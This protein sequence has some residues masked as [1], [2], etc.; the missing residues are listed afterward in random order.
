VPVRDLQEQQSRE[1]MIQVDGGLPVHRVHVPPGHLSGPTA[2]A[3]PVQDAP[4]R[5]E[6]GSVWRR[7]PGAQ[8]R[9]PLLPEGQ[10]PGNDAPGVVW[11]AVSRSP[12]RCAKAHVHVDPLQQ[13]RALNCQLL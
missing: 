3:L 13:Q 11:L 2:L 7:T 8:P 6:D 1:Q 12:Q 5:T 9:E 4:T 10:R